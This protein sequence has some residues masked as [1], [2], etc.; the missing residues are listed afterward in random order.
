VVFKVIFMI[1]S[2]FLLKSRCLIFLFCLY[3]G[4]F[5]FVKNVVFML[6]ELCCRMIFQCIQCRDFQLLHF[7]Q[8]VTLLF[9]QE[10][11]LRRIDYLN[12]KLPDKISP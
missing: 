2:T 5:I 12:G 8:W 3:I 9:G 7:R 6:L 1:K 4:S 11:L 10:L